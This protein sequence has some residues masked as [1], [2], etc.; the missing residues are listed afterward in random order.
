MGIC[1]Q[2]A[3]FVS[4]SRGHGLLSFSYLARSSQFAMQSYFGVKVGS[5][6][7]YFSVTFSPFGLIIALVFFVF[8]LGVWNLYRDGLLLSTF[9]LLVGSDF[10]ARPRSLY[11][12]TC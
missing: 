11:S 8:L 3:Q 9:Y 12:P 5:L 4:D 2:H 10:H 7:A 1:A 6:E